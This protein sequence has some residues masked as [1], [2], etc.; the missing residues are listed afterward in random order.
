MIFF[1]GDHK[2][3][4][5]LSGLILCGGQSLRMGA[6]KALLKRGERKWVDIQIEKLKELGLSYYLSINTQQL[7]HYQPDYALTQ[8]I[9]DQDLGA[10]PLKGILS[11]HHLHPQLDWL[12]LACDLLDIDLTAIQK[13]MTNY[14]KCN[15]D[16]DFYSFYYRQFEPLCAIY[17]VSGLQK[18]FRSFNSRNKPDYSLQTILSTGPTCRIEVPDQDVFQFKNYNSLE[19]LQ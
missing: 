7:D 13:L 6:D 5:N 2:A 1:L 3:V 8:L 4:N 9:V 11:A 12:V 18:V 15:P 19:D 10:G 14:N 17:T 16:Y